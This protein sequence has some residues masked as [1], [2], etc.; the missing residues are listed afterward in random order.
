MALA[1]V[2]GAGSLDVGPNGTYDTIQKVVVNDNNIHD[3]VAESGGGGIW[4]RA[5]DASEVHITGNDVKNNSADL[6]GGVYASVE[7]LG[8]LVID[9]NDISDN[10]ADQ[11]F[12]G[13][14]ASVR[15]SSRFSFDGNQ[16][17]DSQVNPGGTDYGGLYFEGRYHIT[18]VT[19][20]SNSDGSVSDTATDT[21]SSEE[22]PLRA[23]IRLPIV[24]KNY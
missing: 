10:D 8:T 5:H 20:T 22:R 18:T 12:G 1:P 13:V 6:G 14:Y 2:M 16:I 15:Y 4:A 23:T 19:A 17:T 24:F 7:T 3:N 11:Q 21:T 9:D